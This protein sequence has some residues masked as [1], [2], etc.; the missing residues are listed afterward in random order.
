MAGGDKFELFE[1]KMRAEGLSEAAVDAFRYNYQQLVQGVTGMVR[2]L[3]RSRDAGCCADASQTVSRR[4][5]RTTSSHLH[6]SSTVQRYLISVTDCNAQVPE[7]T[8]EAITD[9]PRLESIG[10]ADQEDIKVRRASRAGDCS[11]SC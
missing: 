9:L 4:L 6:P 5:L 1:K 2:M 11:M 8:I 10:S 7:D 3:R